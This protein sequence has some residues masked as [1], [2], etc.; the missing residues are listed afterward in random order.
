MKSFCGITTS[1]TPHVFT[2]DRIYARKIAQRAYFQYFLWVVR[3]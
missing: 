2:I 1:V 3:E